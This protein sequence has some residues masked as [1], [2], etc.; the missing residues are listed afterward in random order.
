MRA[1]T[2]F[3]IATLLPAAAVAAG[4]A[5]G[6]PWL[7]AALGSLT[8]LVYAMDRLIAAVPA[9]EGS[10][11]P[12]GRRLSLL[13]AA[14]HFPLLFLGVYALAGH[15]G[16]SGP[17]IVLGYLALGMFFGQVSNSNAHELIHSPDRLAHRLGAA[18]YISLLYGYHVSSHRFVHHRFVG[19]DDD[20]N[21]ARLGESA[22]GFA[23]R[24]HRGAFARGRAAETEMLRRRDGR[25]P[26]WKHPYT[27]YIGGALAALAA[28]WA[29]AGWWGVLA[30]LALGLYAELQLLVGDYVQ[31][32]GLRRRRD[33]SGRLEPIGPRHSW[34]APQVWSAGVMLNAPK[35]SDH[36]SHP[37]RPF[38]ELGIPDNAPILPRSL[39]VMVAAAYLPP[40]WRRIMDPRVRAL[41][42]ADAA[43]AADA[44]EAGRPA[45][46]GE[47]PGPGRS[48]AAA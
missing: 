13:L 44:V 4:L 2:I 38:T 46:N 28:S 7:L 35:H 11:F 20:P 39:Q 24:A 14:L 23:W 27:V 18:V 3:W 29:I 25:A 22:Y 8:A 19:T 32:Y 34:N 15:T 5:W 9:P 16:L 26:A 48:S 36:H 1:M 31:H 41:R 17:G 40:L 37:A 21:T 43:D 12:A 10:E 6:G 45:G 33:A 30:H 47:G 42:A